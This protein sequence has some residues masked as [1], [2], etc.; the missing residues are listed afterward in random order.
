MAN[1][2]VTV[3][4]GNNINVQVTPTPDQVI[5]I[6]R[7]VAGNGI[8]S[9]TV[10]DIDDYAYLDIVYTNGTSEQIGPIGVS[11]AILIDIENNMVSITAVA[12]NLDVINDV[13]D[14]LAAIQNCD[15]N[16][17]AII[18]APDEAAAAAASATDAADSAAL[19]GAIG[20]AVN[21]IYDQFDDRYLGSKASDPTTNNDGEPLLTGAL[22]WN[23]TSNQMRVYDGTA[24][25]IAYVPASTY[26]EVANNLSDVQSASTSR[27]NLGLGSAAVLD[28]GVADGVAT[29]DGDGTVPISQ[30]PPAVIGAVSYQ[31]TWNASTNTPALA[32][33]V[34]TK[35]YYYV[36]SVAGT[37]N[38]DGITDWQ[39]GDWA[40][41]SGTSWQK[42]DNTELVS[43]VNGYTGA[44]VLSYTDVGA[45]SA[46]QGALADT[47]VQEITSIDGSVSIVPSGTSVDLSVVTAGS[48][49]NVLAQVRNT[50]GATLT[51]GTAVYIS[52]ATGQISTVSKALATS[53]ATS[54]QTL[55]LISADLANNS[56]GYVTVIGLISNI[57][58]SAY[59]DGE[60]LYLSPT[61]AGALTATKPYAPYHM[62]YVAVVERAHPTQGKLFVKVQNGYELDE[63]HNVAAQTPTNGQ[64]I[65]YNSATELWEQN[66]VSLTAGV[67]GTLATTNGGT[68][69]TSF[70][71]GGIPYA[72]STSALTTSTN[73]TYDT[74]Y[75]LQ[76][77]P[78][79]T[80]AA[81]TLVGNSTRA[82]WAPSG[83]SPYQYIQGGSGGTWTF[84]NDVVAGTTSFVNTT[85][86]GA[87][88]TMISINADTG[89]TV[90]QPISFASSATFSALTA[91]GVPFLNGSKQLT[92][93]ASLTY[94]GTTLS[95]PGFS[96]PL[97][98]N[99][100]TATTLQ[101]ARTI[102]GVSFNGSANITVYDSTKLP[103]ANPT[104]TGTMGGEALSVTSITN[105]GT[106]NTMTFK[107]VGTGGT[108]TAIGYQAA[109]GVTASAADNNVILGYQAAYT[110]T[111]PSTSVHIG[112]QAGYSLSGSTSGNS[113][114]GYRAAYNLGAS[115]SANT[116]FGAQAM[117]GT[118]SASGSAY[119]TAVGFQSMYSMNGGDNN[120]AVGGSS[121]YFRSTGGYNTGIGDSALFSGTTGSYNVG[122]G[123]YAG[124]AITTGS[125]NI[126][127]GGFSG[128]SNLDIRTLNNFVVLSDGQGNMR[129]IYGSSGTEIFPFTSANVPATT[130]LNASTLLAGGAYAT[131]GG[132]YTW[133]LPTATDLTTAFGSMPS[134]F[135]FDFA[136]TNGSSGTVTL[137]T[138]TGI[139]TTY[140][141]LVVSAGAG[142]TFRLLKSGA[143]YIVFR[144]AG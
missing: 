25:E 36:V 13:Y 17:A 73:L 1:L 49:T 138:N 124:G 90:S 30:L 67:N 120:T 60:Q 34:G 45:A 119:N 109:N 55:G 127:I 91:N 9:I 84:R 53:D 29:L 26:L 48:T 89:I 128:N 56:N 113:F 2:N 95:A 39:V 110:G 23:T 132:G 28:A 82:V 101:T 33:G 27:T 105:S 114:V 104:Y 141:S 136:V 99:A 58:T 98:G 106:Y 74:V 41:Y 133:T 59:S 63:L 68:G 19:A 130:T 92:T 107:I 129:K 83:G 4:D 51:K 80:G 62:V 137:A 61:T 38:L 111:T 54:A 40:I 85:T 8:E 10:V 50:T 139:T 115:N 122:I 118:A 135:A 140:G 16:M 102:N 78:G 57:N 103:I 32:S 46:A 47:A 131:G 108:S 44:V 81:I 3:V 97:T 20:A 66:T 75:G 76:V 37:T 70:T 22:Y 69:L 43:S 42:I 125:Y 65:V 77:V 7:G 79:G 31:G 6:D 35:G 15:T 11:S 112:S 123:Y 144:V 52:G 142:A 88:T 86:G 121:Q 116:A 64:T 71:N 12:D 134:N 117:Q 94:N 126:V 96:G 143:N 93:S 5:N 72:T 100:S 24:W 14:N 21:N 87:P 18:A